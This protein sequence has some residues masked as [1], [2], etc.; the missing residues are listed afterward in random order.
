MTPLIT[1]VLAASYLGLFLV[2]FAE[3]GL[4]LGFF[5]PGD[6]LLIA[7]GLLCAQ[8]SLSLPLVM[9]ACALGAVLGDSVG[10]ALGWKFGPGVFERSSW[11]KSEYL[12]QTRAYYGR[13]GWTTLGVARFIPVVRTFAP[14]LAGAVKMPYKGFLVYNVLGGIVWGA[15]V[16]L[17]GAWLGRLVP[18]LD[19]YILLVIAAVVLA[20]LAPVAREAWR[21]GN[22][23][24]KNRNPI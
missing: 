2:V 3:T 11:L 23:W 17:A 12:E 14:T 21:A 8:G 22:E 5:L 16:P 10:Y 24:L 13:Y 6:S 9:L 1:T 20:S 4:L 18:H 19:R 7:A 15:G